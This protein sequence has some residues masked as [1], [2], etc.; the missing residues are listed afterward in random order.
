VA[1]TGFR[2]GGVSGQFVTKFLSQPGSSEVGF[3]YGDPLVRSL[4]GRLVG[5]GEISL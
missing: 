5:N 4:A 3:G 2:T 1:H